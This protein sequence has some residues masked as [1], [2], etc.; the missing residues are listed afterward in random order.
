MP[1]ME[2]EK[3]RPEDLRKFIAILN[4]WMSPDMSARFLQEIDKLARTPRQR[5]QLV[6]THGDL[7]HGNLLLGTEIGGSESKMWAIDLELVGPRPFETD[8]AYMFFNMAISHAMQTYP[9]IASRRGFMQVYLAS[10][11]LAH[12]TSAVEDALFAIEKEYPFQAI[13]IACSSFYF[14]GDA[15]HAHFVLSILP[16]V[17]RIL[18]AAESNTEI[19]RRVVEMG[20][21]SAA[22]T[23][24]TVGT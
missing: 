17:R 6:L 3:A 5:S 19:K 9:S 20:A 13:F 23:Q 1:I 16:Q 15:S 12:D 8:L 10:R 21:A 7:H 24:S 11:G 22:W 4:E 2:K 18:A 14:V